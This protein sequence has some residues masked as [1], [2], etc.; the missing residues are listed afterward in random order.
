[1][2]ENLKKFNPEIERIGLT[3]WLA[4]RIDKKYML[5]GPTELSRSQPE[6][7]LGSVLE[8]IIGL[9]VTRGLDKQD[10]HQP[11]QKND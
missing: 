3:K 6:G 9:I 7:L 8:G 2:L 10:K 5:R 1:L 11:L 4:Q